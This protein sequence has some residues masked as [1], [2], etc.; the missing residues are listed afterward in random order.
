MN[1]DELV[2]LAHAAQP[3]A[4]EAGQARRTARRIQR[5]YKHATAMGHSL[6]EDLE[7]RDPLTI[8]SDEA[9]RITRAA[10]MAKLGTFT[11]TCGETGHMSWSD[12]MSMILGYAPGAVQPSA[13]LLFNLIHEED[14]DDFREAIKHS[15]QQRSVRQIT[16]RVVRPDGIV[17][18]MH[19]HIEV[20][21]TEDGQPSGIIGT[22]QDVT[23]RELARREME[24]LKRRC[25]TVLTVLADRE[26]DTCLLTRR[27]FLDE[28]DRALRA[29]S[30][31][32]LVLSVETAGE[33]HPQTTPGGTARAVMNEQLVGS[34]AALVTNL[35]SRGDMCGRVGAN[36]IGVLMHNAP[37]RLAR[38]T[39][40]AVLET[41]RSQEF[42][43]RHSRVRAQAWGGLVRYSARTEADS[44]DLL[45]DAES[46]W[47]RAKA[48]GAALKVLTEPAP[49]AERRDTCRGRILTAIQDN[50][51]TLYAQPILDLNLN[52]VTRHEIL[53]RLLDDTNAPVAPAGF[54]DIA[55]RVDEILAIDMMV[56]DRALLLI[57]E[58]PETAHYHVNLSG[59]SLGDDRLLRH[60]DDQIRR[61]NVDAGQ[62]TFE[63][64][65]TA[66]IGNMTEARRFAH[67]VR[68][69]GCQLAL[70]DFGSGYGSFTY[71]KYFPIDLV[72]IDGDFISKICTTK[73]DQVMVRSVVDICAALGIR[74]IA[75][76]AEDAPTVDL[77]RGYGIEFAQ[78][79]AIGKPAP[80]A[81]SRTVSSLALPTLGERSAKRDIPRSAAG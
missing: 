70:D 23:N 30:G 24:R 67:S 21:V 65:E 64:T 77:L 18:H 80:I 61:L 39:A 37:T 72:K 63:I 47:R 19:C 53:L 76:F 74:T 20:L 41:L 75:E 46:A 12:E 40:E 50:R 25:E 73:V 16:C 29:G 45:V 69:L 54:L 48:R 38:A 36:E 22:G 9:A 34:V 51:F 8:D 7:L 79:Y 13:E 11:W 52:Q 57:A 42:L 10:Q 27:R 17:R 3:S 62:L 31:A 68:E 15:W 59:R 58:G 66:V 71:L 55:E 81:Q 32:L 28:I 6:I 49:A 2:E 43:V 26:P 4:L 60:V 14:H 1:L 44:L 5:E 56:L 78:G 33:S 35:V